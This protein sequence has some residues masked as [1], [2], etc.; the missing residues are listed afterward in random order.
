MVSVIIRTTGF[1]INI[2]LLPLSEVLVIIH[3]N[4]SPDFRKRYLLLSLTKTALFSS[5][6]VRRIAT[7]NA[8][9]NMKE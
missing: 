2:L 1:N 4:E 8:T 3:F 7:L 6:H 9:V 5:L